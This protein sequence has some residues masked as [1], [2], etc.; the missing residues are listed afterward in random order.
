MPPPDPPTTPSNATNAN[1]TGLTGQN[2]VRDPISLMVA[3]TDRDNEHNTIRPT[4]IPMAC[5]KLEDLT[6]EFDSSFILPGVPASMREFKKLLDA[7]PKSPAAV[8]GHADPVGNDEYN[9]LLAGRRAQAVYGLLTRRTDLWEDL[10]K[11]AEGSKAWGNKSVQVMLDALGFPP[12]RADGTIDQ[13]TKD[14]IKSFQRA[15]GLSE[16]GSAGPST[17]KALYAKYMDFLCVDDKDQPYSL[18]KTDFL[19]RG[20]DQNLKADMQGCGEF[21]PILMFS[22]AESDAFAKDKDKTARDAENAPNRRVMILLFRPGSKVDPAK[23]PCPRVKEGTGACR[24][25]FWSD[26]DKKRQ[27][28][29]KRREFKDT[30]DTF[31]CRFYQRLADSSPCERATALAAFRYAI[32]MHPELPWTKDATIR[33]TSED[34]THI[35]TLARKDAFEDDTSHTFAFG[36]FRIGVKYRAEL[37]EDKLILGLFDLA[38]ISAIQNPKNEINHV[39]L[40]PPDGPTPPEGRG[41]TEQTVPPPQFALTKNIPSSPLTQ[42]LTQGSP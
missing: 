1:A 35:V 3:P 24:K 14:A 33:F 39:P 10:H 15:N 42:N 18:K 34:G 41:G 30:Q 5:F 40:A 25:R 21:N 7:H 23:W 4:I 17:R 12:G 6:F 13:P 32:Q 28:Q 27:F 8:F 26:A 16:D 31:A 9:K 22:K 20:A 2:V 36:N 11:Q 37:I 19:A 29:E 38:D